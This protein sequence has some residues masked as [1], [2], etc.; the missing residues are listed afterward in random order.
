MLYALAP[1]YVTTVDNIPSLTLIHSDLQIAATG[2][3]FSN[4]ACSESCLKPLGDFQ[5]ELAI[6][7][8][9][10]ALKR[11]LG[12][13]LVNKACGNTYSLVHSLLLVTVSSVADL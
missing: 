11:K 12:S 5:T 13:V 7:C 10:V 2:I 4:W 1:V 3:E 6:S 8:S 9:T